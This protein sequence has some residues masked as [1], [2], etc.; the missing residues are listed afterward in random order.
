MTSRRLGQMVLCILY[1]AVVG[2]ADAQ[3]LAKA[4]FAGGCF[5]CME[6][7]FHELADVISTT[8]GDTGG[9]SAN[10]TYKEISAGRTDHAEAVEVVYD[11]GR[12]TFLELL[13][14]RALGF[15]RQPA[16]HLV[17]HE[18]SRTVLAADIAKLR[19]HRQG[20]VVAPEDL[21]QLRIPVVTDIVAATQFWPAED[22]HQDYYKKNLIRYKFY[23]TY[24]G[25]DRHCELPSNLA[26]SSRSDRA[27]RPAGRL[28]INWQAEG[29]PALVRLGGLIG[30]TIAA[31]QSQVI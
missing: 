24:F 21:Q 16:L 22:Y 8:S 3:E 25:R 19:V 26:A 20:I 5:W 29:Y 9:R 7:P 14:H 17:V 30:C 15:F 11:P 10:P 13:G 4:T 12:I 18:D 6:P 23:R 31:P 27:G 1:L 28:Y 2:A